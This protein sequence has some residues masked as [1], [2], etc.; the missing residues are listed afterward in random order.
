M[1]T[2]LIISMVL[3]TIGVIGQIALIGEPRNPRTKT[4]AVVVL[5][6]TSANIYFL[7]RIYQAL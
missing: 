4:D 2:Y 3:Q 5:L 6:L 7:L 1:K